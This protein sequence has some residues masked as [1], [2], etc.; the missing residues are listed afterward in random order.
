[1]KLLDFKTTIT[2]TTPED[3][4]QISCIH[5]KSMSLGKKLADKEKLARAQRLVMLGLLTV[6]LAACGSDG[7]DGLSAYQIWLNA[8]NVGTEEDFLEFLRGEGGT[9]GTP[10]T[11]GLPGA[12]GPIGEPGAPGEPGADGQDAPTVTFSLSDLSQTGEYIATATNASGLV[13]FDQNGSV[14]F[15]SVEMVGETTIFGVSGFLPGDLQAL[16]INGLDLVVQS[17]NGAVYD[18][19]LSNTAITGQ[20][21]VVILASADSTT[22]V[23][24]RIDGN[25][26]FDMSSDAVTL[27]L[28]ADSVINIT[29]DLIIDDGLLDASALDMGS[30]M[31][32]GIAGNI[33]LNSGLIAA[34]DFFESFSGEISGTG[35][36]T[37][38]VSSVQDVEKLEALF[39]SANNSDVNFS[40]AVSDT[41]TDPVLQEEILGAIFNS[42]ELPNENDDGSPAF[43]APTGKVLLVTDNGP[44]LF[45]T[46]QDAIEASDAGDTIS[47]GSGDY[48][49]T[50]TIDKAVLVQ[51]ADGAVL[52]GGFDVSAT[53]FMLEGGTVREGGSIPSVAG[54][55]AVFVR[56]GGEVTVKNTIIDGAGS[57][58]QDRGV[59][60]GVGASEVTLEGATFV[61]WVGSAVYVNPGVALTVNN[62]VFT[63]NLVGIGT[64]GPATLFVTNS[65]FDNTAEGIGL[66]PGKVV[67]ELQL[68]NNTF[69]ESDQIP[70]AFGGADTFVTEI[71]LTSDVIFVTSGQ[72]IQSAIDQTPEG[73]T[74]IVGPGTYN[75]NLSITKEVS[76]ISAQGRV[77]TK[78]VGS[79]ANSL[80]GTIDIG[81][82]VNGV[83]IKG[84]TIEGIN[85]N[86]SLEKAAVYVRGNNEG[87]NI[88]D[89]ELIAKGDSALT[90]EFGGALKNTFID[91]NIFSG[92]TFV[93]EDPDVSSTVQFDPDNNFPRQLVVLG[94]G[95]GLDQSIS[96]DV[97]FS[98]NIVSGTAGGATG[99]PSVPFGNNLVTID[100]SGALITGNTFIGI[101][102]NN[103]AALRSRRDDTE[104][105]DN[106]FDQSGDGQFAYPNSI[107]VQNNANGEI[108]GNTVIGPDGGRV[109]S[110]ADE[111]GILQ[112]TN[113][114]DFL[115]GGAGEDIFSFSTT[116]AENGSDIVV[117]FSAPDSLSFRFAL[118]GEISQSDL[119]GDGT[120]FQS[121]SAPEAVGADTGFIVISVSQAD[122][123]DTTALNL[124][125]NLTGLA[126]G[127]QFYLAFDDGNDTAIYRIVDD[128]GNGFSPTTAERLITLNDFAAEDLTAGMLVNFV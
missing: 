80:L 43:V 5:A 9:P 120:T 114:S 63:D 3:L 10:G 92:K 66:T 126:D 74:V 61:N 50:I 88:L 62:S 81:S 101:T 87:L 105:S 12:E 85:G 17:V 20:G 6:P 118:P 54:Q 33:D 102:G 113:G 121:F 48:T 103:V 27:T 108:T 65:F 82:N 69:T 55:H 94:N 95:G 89:N 70:L 38:I 35:D 68:T 122:M 86:G 4:A 34:I 93:G 124:A 60:A 14:R 56:P 44:Q 112:A 117:D 29:G 67:G 75:E 1:M 47:V 97:T 77:D 42:D 49:G 45:D 76:L 90:S 57:S 15:D 96:T 53:G 78:I 111:G 72:S 28:T 115:L 127:D 125:N 31:A 24:I 39:S 41:V 59:E 73:G 40:F 99:T 19:F 52:T 7:E 119:R 123:D 79:D 116:L 30:L 107:F 16:D 2:E 106:V 83:T 13:V 51:M 8:G 64:D 11:P 26:T 21:N 100:V 98:N 110:A 104:I 22:A 46:I 71:A 18:Q 37:I 36:L 25:L 91:G 84:F 58:G 109:L 23:D 128:A 32:S